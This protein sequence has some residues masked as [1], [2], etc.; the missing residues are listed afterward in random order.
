MT[1]DLAPVLR[2]T[3]RVLLD[4]DGPVCS[5]FAGLSAADVADSMRQQLAASG[6]P[7]APEWRAESDPLALLRRIGDQRPEMVPAADAVLTDLEISAAH[8]ARL[9]PD[10]KHLLDACVHTGRAVLVVSNN[11][12]AAIAGYLDREGLA[13]V[14]RVVGRVPEEPASMKP[15][16]RL[17]LDAMEATP[18]DACVFIGDAVRDVEAGHAAGVRTIGYANKPGKAEKLT[19]AGAAVVV[20]SL[21]PIADALTSVDSDS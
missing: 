15:S 11:A 7:I 8:R 21:M 3:T 14:Q 13:Q 6:H 17:L 9:N 4:F 2:G 1:G 5:I 20:D 18:P 10:I 16:P 19:A 12:G